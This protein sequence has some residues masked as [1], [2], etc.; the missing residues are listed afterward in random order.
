[1]LIRAFV[2]RQ[3]GNAKT[4]TQELYL[5][6]QNGNMLMHGVISDFV[7]TSQIRMAMSESI[8]TWPQRCAEP[9][10]GRLACQR[11]PPIMFPRDAALPQ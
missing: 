3:E 9:Q 10:R 6:N 4:H 11:L 2:F 1:M 8:G 7:S 5:M